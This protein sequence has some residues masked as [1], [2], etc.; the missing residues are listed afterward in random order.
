MSDLLTSMKRAS[1]RFVGVVADTGAKTMLKTDMVFLER[2]IKT[3]KQEFGLS[4]FDIL[5]SNSSTTT[6]AAATISASEIQTAFEECQADIHHLE[7]KVQNK[8]REMDAIDQSSSGGGGG[9]SS[10][11][12]GG[13]GGMD[14]AETP[15][16][17]ST[18]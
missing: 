6:T 1:Q 18:P 16:I 13:G 7:A 15:G 8:K 12:V 9:G 3:R 5:Q 17:P 10:S 11:S 4:I 2:D 14:D